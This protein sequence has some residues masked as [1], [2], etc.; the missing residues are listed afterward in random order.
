[1]MM[2]ALGASACAVATPLVARAGEEP[3]AAATSEPVRVDPSSS[4]EAPPTPPESPAASPAAAP[5]AGEGTPPTAA[6]G[7]SAEAESLLQRPRFL[8]SAAVGVSIDNHGIADGRNVI[9]PSLAIGGGIGDGLFGFEARL[10][11]SEAAGR[12]FSPSPDGTKQ[13]ADV[14][15]DRQALDILLAVRPFAG[16]ATRGDQPWV[17]RLVRSLTADLGFAVERV[18]VGTLSTLRG[19]AVVG[20]HLDVP[21]VRSQDGSELRVTIAARRMLGRSQTLQ[22]SGV[23]A[24]VGDSK[25]ESFAGLTVVF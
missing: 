13:V 6:S 16:G 23:T 9:V 14:G 3:L 22:V 20:A 10:F 11:A 25:L 18:S 8:A 15:A 1:M 24:A 12:F 7:S 5:V 2:V 21:L 4:S 19:G 17:A